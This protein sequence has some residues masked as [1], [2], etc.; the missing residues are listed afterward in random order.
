MYSESIRPKVDSIFVE[1]RKRVMT[2]V[3][4]SSTTEEAA[5]KVV[6]LISSELATRSKSIL[7]DMLF[8]LTDNLMETDFF[9]EVSKQ[10]KFTE[11]NIRQEI[12]NKYQFSPSSNVDYKEAS[13][14]TNA[15]MAGCFSFGLGG[16]IEI[17]YIL[18]SGLKFSTLFPIPISVL[19][20]ASFGLAL[21]D[22]YA[23]EPNRSKKSFLNAV[24]CYLKK[25][26]KQFFEWFDEVENYFNGRV[27]EIK[28]II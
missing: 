12:L 25:T 3:S 13:K 11:I 22:Y 8:T 23:I 26:Q 21:T 17:G 28:Q 14:V 6:L 15:I 5:N 18:I 20:I 2:I 9:R 16:V 1:L 10:N 19:L 27:E 7:S 4:E 24:D